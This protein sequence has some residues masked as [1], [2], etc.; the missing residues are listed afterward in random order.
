M[1]CSS[2]VCMYPS[3]CGQRPPVSFNKARCPF[4]NTH[5]PRSATQ[6]G[7]FCLSPMPVSLV[8]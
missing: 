3:L 2:R 6:S 7:V 4:S 5:A 8:R 1:V